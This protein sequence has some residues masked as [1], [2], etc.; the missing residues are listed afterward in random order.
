MNKPTAGR[1]LEAVALILCAAAIA[2][3]LGG[4]L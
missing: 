1:R 3:T 2:L 4:A